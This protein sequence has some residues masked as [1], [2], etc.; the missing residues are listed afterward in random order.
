MRVGS[1]QRPRLQTRL[2][3]CASL[4][5]GV[6]FYFWCSVAQFGLHIRMPLHFSSFYNYLSEVSTT[7][8]SVYV[9]QA[10]VECHTLYSYAVEVR[11]VEYSC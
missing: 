4:L 7:V 5:G 1:G 9:P 6:V 10:E 8:C 3:I 2:S 11:A